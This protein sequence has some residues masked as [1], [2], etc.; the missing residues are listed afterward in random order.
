MER[1]AR[2][3][4]CPGAGEIAGA[5]RQSRAA[6]LAGARNDRG[7]P[8]ELRV[9]SSHIVT[10]KFVWKTKRNA[11]GE[12]TG[13]KARL[14]AQGNRQRDGIDFSETFAPVARFS[15][16]RC[17]LALAAANGYHV[18]QA[19]IDKAY[20]HGELDH[21]IWMTTPRGF[22]FPSDK[23]LRLRR[24]IYGLKQ[25]GRIWNRHI[26]TSLR[27]LGY[28]ATGTDHCIYS[29]ID[30]QQRP[31]YI[32]LYVDDLL[33]VSPA[34]DEIERVISG[35]EQRYGVKRLGPAEYILGIQIRRLDDG[36]I[37]LSQE[38]YI[39][40]V[41]ARFHFDT[42]TRGTTVPMTPGLSLTAIPGQG[43]ERIRSWYLQAIGSLLYISLGTRPDIAFAVSYLSRFANNPGR[44]HWIAVKHVLRYLRATY[45][46][47]LLYARG[48]AKVTGVVG[49][50]DANWGACVDT[51]ISTMGYVFYLAG[52]AVSWSS[53]RQTRVADSTTDAEY[54]AL[55]HAGK[56]AIYLNQLLSE[57]HVCPIAA[58]HIFTDNE[59]A[60]AVAHDPVRTSGTRHIRLREHFVRDMVNRG[61]ISLSHVGTAD[62]V[63]D[64]FTKALGPK[65]FGTHCYALGLR[66]R[67]PR[68][69]STSRSRGGGA[70]EASLGLRRAERA[71]AIGSVELRSISLLGQ[72]ALTEV[73]VPRLLRKICSWSRIDYILVQCSWANR[74]LSASTLFD[75]PCSD[76][77]PVVATF[78]LPTSNADAEP[79]LSL[80]STSDFISR[81]NPMVFD[82]QDFVASIP[83]VVNEVYRRLEGT[84]PL[85]DVYDAALRAVAVA[86]HARYRSTCADMRQLR[87]ESQSVME[88]LEAR[89]EHMNEAERD[90]YALAKSRLDQLAV[91]E[92]QWLRIRAHVPSVDSREGQ[93][94]SIRMRLN[95]RSRQTSIVSLED[96]DG[97][98]TVDMQ[99]AL[100]IASRHAQSLF[101]PDPARGDPTNAHR[102]L[103]NPI[104]AAKCYDD[105]RSDPTFGRRLPRQARVAL[106]EPFTL[107][108]IEAAL[109]KTDSGRSPGPSGIPYELFKALP[110][111]FAPKLLDLFNSIWEGGKMMASLAEELVRD[112]QRRRG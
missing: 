83:G 27:N 97:T 76:H 3:G 46:D 33:I 106:D 109:K 70:R 95:R 31:H 44:R 22:D 92:A 98:E 49:Y 71:W 112:R 25:A 30:D 86:G 60:A 66:T 32:A 91:K 24:S 56:E 54:L 35:L 96:V 20:L 5:L 47:E 77:R 62:M 36:S 26:D 73:E 43:T 64:V 40:D 42:T 104:R 14:V 78:A 2:A 57:L 102:S 110:T 65:I 52:A 90:A 38:R 85:G 11:S 12:V 37:A 111:Y 80:P 41:L 21:D 55:S 51:S 63:A 105:D 93:S 69:K 50:S 99:E 7:A 34:L 84:T 87:A 100:G 59:A 88:A 82:D 4:I 28:K 48:P 107:L 18:H 19:D 89:G 68:L 8:V 53:K 94:A 39:M 81:L 101:T 23:V 108:E 13:R 67:H 10:S 61:D 16:I 75:A 1:G 72:Y 74:L 58:A 6:K 9:D 103:L 17:L 45:R 79:P 29:R 15:S